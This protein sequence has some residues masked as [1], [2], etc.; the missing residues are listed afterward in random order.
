MAGT[1]RVDKCHFVNK[2]NRRQVGQAVFVAEAQLNITDSLFENLTCGSLVQ[3][4]TVILIQG[5]TLYVNS[6]NFTGNGV[7]IIDAWFGFGSGVISVESGEAYIDNSVFINNSAAVGGVFYGKNSTVELN[8][9]LFMNNSASRGG[10][11]ELDDSII[12]AFD[13]EFI[14]NF[15]QQDG[16]VFYAN[17]GDLNHSHC[18]FIGNVAEGGGRRSY[19]L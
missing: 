14:N 18:R 3:P 16:G 11:A 4:F 1:G 15:A 2:K 5:G 6:S 10:V 13:C 8:H 9:C 7:P 17:E 12:S 19:L